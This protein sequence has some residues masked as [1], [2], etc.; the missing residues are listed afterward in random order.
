[1]GKKTGWL[2]TVKKVFKHS[3][4]DLDR[5]RQREREVEAEGNEALE[6]VSVEHFPAETSPEATNDDGGSP[7]LAV[8]EDR[9]HA[10]AVAVA[11]AAA[12]EAAAAAAE[13]AAQ[14]V[15]LAGYGRLSREEKAAVRI[16]SYYRG[17]LARRALR[18]LR[19]LVRLQALVRGHHVRKQA[20]MTMRCMQAL[21]RV[22]AGVRARRL[23]LS[24]QSHNALLPHPPSSSTTTTP[25]TATTTKVLPH[26]PF[27]D[28]LDHLKAK[29][30]DH[31]DEEDFAAD[32]EE[33]EEQGTHPIS[34]PSKDLGFG[35]WDTSHQ[36]LETIKANSQRKQDAVIRRERALAYA[37]ASQQWKSEK[38]QWG[39]NWLERWMATQQ[40]Q[41]P[42]SL[43]QESSY[44]TV[45]NTD[46]LSEK[47]VEMDLGRSPFNPVH[48]RRDETSEVPS[49]MAATQS[50]RAKFRSQA[51]VARGYGAKRNQSTWRA[52][53][54]VGGDS[55]S[56]GGARRSPS[57]VGG[58]LRVQTRRHAGYS[59]P[60]SSCAGGDRTPPV[61]GRG[62][63]SIYV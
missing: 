39:W 34:N 11:T 43:P 20:Q 59:T 51:P 52:G 60:D 36:S 24:Q 40:W 18:A 49:Y 12:A 46:D 57:H 8:E 25:T 10:I 16:Q 31:H 1:M 2:S 22:Q 17:Y 6:I 37:Y 27:S 7:R 50:A 5:R 55:S 38:P 61:G 54:G 21:V 9:E 47:T 3:S 48:S 14:V 42:Q 15:R 30:R 4:K 53:S 29:D 56:S 23:Q 19:G 28:Y 41:A 32:D 62:R 35:D 33:E 26:D 45:T 63:R 58:G 13:A 44:V